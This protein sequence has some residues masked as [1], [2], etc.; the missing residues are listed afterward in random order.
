MIITYLGLEQF[1]IQFGDTTIALNPVSKESKYKAGRFGADIALVS[2]NDKD[3]NGVEN[4]THGDRK[5][6]SVT[7]PGEY[8]IKGIF[9][10]G[11]KSESHY[12]LP[13]GSKETRINT[14]YSISLEG[15]NL[16][17]LGALD[18]KDLSVETKEA[19]DD[20]DVLFVPIGGEGTL[21]P[22]VAYELAVK[23]E[24][25]LIIPMHY[26]DA[27]DKNLKTFLKEAGEEKIKPED[28]LTLKKKDLEG[29]EGDVA[30]LL[31][32]V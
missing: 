23:L 17:F 19:L 2:L 1:K 31:P 27:G 20:I 9:I 12:G 24:P 8:E 13:A 28:K 25:K 32:Q 7:G 5:P 15:M 6:F 18:S 22:A 30:V 3:F 4:V 10:K 21:A 16:C 11:F 14:I 26:N 29:K